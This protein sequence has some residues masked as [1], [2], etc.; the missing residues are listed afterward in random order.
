MNVDPRFVVGSVAGDASICSNNP[1]FLVVT[2][3]RYLVSSNLTFVVDNL[4]CV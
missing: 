2:T 4:S 1:N 3:V